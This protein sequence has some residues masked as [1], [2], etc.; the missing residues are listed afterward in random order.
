[1][2]AGLEQTKSQEPLPRQTQHSS[3]QDMLSMNSEPLLVVVS[4]HKETEVPTCPGPVN[5]QHQNPRPAAYLV[6]VQLCHAATSTGQN[7]VGFKAAS[8]I[9]NKH[10]VYSVSFINLLATTVFSVKTARREINK[11]HENRNTHTCSILIRSIKINCV[12]TSRFQVP[13]EVGTC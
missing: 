6:P 4:T 3:A 11:K 13:R 12:F 7:C 1:M 10:T 8:L 2:G 5:H 9:Y